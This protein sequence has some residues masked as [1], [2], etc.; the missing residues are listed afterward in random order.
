M[1]MYNSPISV[2]TGALE[3]EQMM[4]W[5]L[6]THDTNSNMIILSSKHLHKIIALER[7]VFVL[8]LSR[9]NNT[10]DMIQSS[11]DSSRLDRLGVVA[12]VVDTIAEVSGLGVD[13]L[14]ALVMFKHGLPIVYAGVLQE[15]NI[16]KVRLRNN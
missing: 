13:T 6:E 3:L 12:V 8:F 9:H 15:E 14:P 7:T 5:L 16:E 2:Y 1:I 4:T 10:L 11:V